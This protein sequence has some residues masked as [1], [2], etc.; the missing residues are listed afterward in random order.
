MKLPRPFRK[1]ARY[2]CEKVRHGSRAEAERVRDLMVAVKGVAVGELESYRCR[3]CKGW[4][5]GHPI[6]WWRDRHG[7]GPVGAR[8]GGPA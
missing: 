2:R 7:L 6:G 4:H 8:L 1:H 3:S 5:L